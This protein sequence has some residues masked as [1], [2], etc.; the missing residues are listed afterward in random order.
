M[1][2]IIH[3]ALVVL[4]VSIGIFYKMYPQMPNI[5]QHKTPTFGYRRIEGFANP[6]VAPQEPKCVQRSKDAQA[7]LSIIGPCRDAKNSPS[8]DDVDRQELL[9]ILQKLTC[10]DA[11]VN[12]NG[13]AGY[14]TL[15]L[16]YNTSHDTEPL[17][18]FIGR[19]LNNGTRSR[20]LEIVIDKYETRGKALINKITGRIGMDSKALLEN[21]QVV[22]RTTMKS[23]TDTCL[24]AQSNLDRPFGPRDPGYATP[25]SVER[26][27]PF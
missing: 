7:I 14:N 10:L 9:L 16:P 12:N 19:C 4:I 15:Y 18:N 17:T 5:R 1:E 26:L 6:A 27:A 13:V 3:I 20:D 25:F 8:E 22:I 2:V 21:Y 23:M 24:A 11:D